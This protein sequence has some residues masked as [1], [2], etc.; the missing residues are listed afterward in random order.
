MELEKQFGSTLGHRAISIY[1]IRRM[2][3]VWPRLVVFL[4]QQ[5]IAQ[6]GCLLHCLQCVNISQRLRFLV[7]HTA[8]CDTLEIFLVSC[9]DCSLIG[10]L[11]D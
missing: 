6:E 9:L 10:L 1:M 11:I 2:S 4:P 5:Y 8:A 7:I 3:F